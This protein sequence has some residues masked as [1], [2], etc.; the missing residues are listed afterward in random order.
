MKTMVLIL[1]IVMLARVAAGQGSEMD[2][3]RKVVLPEFSGGK[4]FEAS[5]GYASINEYLRANVQYP[6]ESCI[7]KYQGTVVVRFLVSPNGEISGLNVINGVC[8][9]ME[10]EVVRV[11]KSTDGGWIPGTINGKPVAM[12]REV[13]VTFKIDQSCDF[14]KFATDY[15]KHGNDLLYLKGNPR[16]ALKY[17]NKG[18]S[19]MP[20]DQNLLIARSLCFSQLG[21]TEQ[22][23]KDWNR[24]QELGRSEPRNA[25]LIAFSGN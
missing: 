15:L 10:E 9:K 21:D 23:E 18:I 25:V 3:G 11:L 22:A 2:D 16:K 20:R 4:I 1:F 8:R 5:P 14:V 13:A 24:L 12:E 17:Y 19:L 6:A 7:C